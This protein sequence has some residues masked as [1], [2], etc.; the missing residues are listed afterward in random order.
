M[1]FGDRSPPSSYVCL[2]L[3]HLLFLLPCCLEN[4]SYLRGA[5]LDILRSFFFLARQSQDTD[6]SESVKAS[7]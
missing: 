2:S 6:P 5:F 3:F 1:T 7:F 4:S